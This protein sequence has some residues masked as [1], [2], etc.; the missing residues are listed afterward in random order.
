MPDAAT[1]FLYVSLFIISSSQFLI[2]CLSKCKCI[3]YFCQHNISEERFFIYY[4]L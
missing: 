3:Y 4:I 2:R 1:I